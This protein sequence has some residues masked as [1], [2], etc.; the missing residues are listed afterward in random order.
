VRS[1][2]ELVAAFGRGVNDLVHA[3]KN[4]VGARRTRGIRAGLELMHRRYGDD[5]TLAQVAK[6]AGFAPKY[7]S[8]L[9]REQQGKTFESYLTQL[10]FERAKQLLTGSELN[11]SRIAELCGFRTPQYLAE[12]FRRELDKTPLE[13]RHDTLPHWARRGKVRARKPRTRS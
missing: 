12:V 11:A 3:A 6:A 13:Y 5:L 8:A 2:R 9:F 4:P 10:R 7:F 1:L